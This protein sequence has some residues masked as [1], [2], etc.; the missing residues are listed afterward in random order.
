M[1]IKRSKAEAK[2]TLVER[3]AQADARARAT[4]D[5]LARAAALHKHKAALNALEQ[6]MIRGRTFVL[7]T[8]G[9]IML[10][11][12]WAL[13]AHGAVLGH[14]LTI[15]D[16]ALMSAHDIDLLTIADALDCAW[17]DPVERGLWQAAYVSALRRVADEAEAVERALVDR[18]ALREIVGLQPNVDSAP[19]RRGTK[20]GPKGGM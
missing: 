2:K 8:L 1:R 12:V 18:A 10:T 4:I 14:V 20:G 3:R 7:H 9:D 15:D 6:I 19:T 13:D 17:G 5:L 16:A 11:Q